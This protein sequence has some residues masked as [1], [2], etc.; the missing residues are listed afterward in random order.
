MVLT[1]VQ[2]AYNKK[3]YAKKWRENNLEISRKWSKESY[4]KK[5]RTNETF[6]EYEQIRSL[7]KYYTNSLAKIEEIED[8][9]VADE[10]K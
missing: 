4:Q 10:T 8:I 3:A 1:D 2:K 9:V 6:R 7:V 5:N